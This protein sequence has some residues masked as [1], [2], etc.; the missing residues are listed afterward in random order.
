MLTTEQGKKFNEKKEKKNEEFRELPKPKSKKSIATGR[1]GKGAEMAR[2]RANVKVV[3]TVK[4]TKGNTIVWT[5]II[6]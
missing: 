2:I 5:L 3:E 4:Q 6:S 1:V